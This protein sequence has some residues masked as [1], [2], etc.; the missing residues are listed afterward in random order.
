MK[1]YQVS[2]SM[3]QV[4]HSEVAPRIRSDRELD[5]QLHRAARS[6]VL[7][8]AE[9]VGVGRGKRRDQHFRIA[10]GSAREVMAVI[11]LA[12]ATGLVR[13]EHVAAAV[14]RVDHVCAMLWKLTR[15]VA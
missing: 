7:N 5:D 10:L 9:G 6:V 13:K 11:D 12:V 3:V 15:R 2:V 1:V 4:V 14:D 8:V